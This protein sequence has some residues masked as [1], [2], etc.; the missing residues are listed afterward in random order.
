MRKTR[1]TEIN[2][3]I[4][5]AVA[6]RTNSVVIAHCT[7]CGRPVRMVAANEAAMIARISSR[8]IYRAVEAGG[9]HFTEDHN[10]LLFVCS[11]S[12]RQLGSESDSTE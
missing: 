4:E 10:G 8:E 11:S 3:E 2:L 7:V 9:L 6:I 12:L 1:K 5:E